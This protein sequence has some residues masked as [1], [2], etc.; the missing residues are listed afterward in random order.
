MPSVASSRQLS[1][2]LGFPLAALFVSVFK[3]LRK[4]FW[5][6]GTGQVLGG[7]CWEGIIADGVGKWDAEN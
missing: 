3:N 4:L 1:I 7:T 6:I 2:V 5:L